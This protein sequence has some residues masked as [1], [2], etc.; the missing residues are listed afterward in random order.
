MQKIACP[1]VDKLNAMSLWLEE[2]KLDN[3][4]SLFVF[5]EALQFRKLAHLAVF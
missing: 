5:P 1:S 4:T 2:C 3:C